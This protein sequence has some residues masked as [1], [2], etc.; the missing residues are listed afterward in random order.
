MAHQKDR[1]EEAKVSFLLEAVQGTEWGLRATSRVTDKYSY[2]SHISALNTSFRDLALL[3][4]ACNKGNTETGQ[5]QYMRKSL[6]KNRKMGVGGVRDTLYR[7]RER[8]GR[9]PRRINRS[10]K[11]NRYKPYLGAKKFSGACFNYESQEC[12]IETYAKPNF[13]LAQVLEG[14]D[15]HCQKSRGVEEKEGILF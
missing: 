7:G 3:K 11:K 5:S 8:Y 1:D 4:Q 10:A 6:W 9:N 14:P 2:Q 12:S 13:G 15:S